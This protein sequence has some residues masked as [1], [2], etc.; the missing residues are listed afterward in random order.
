MGLENDVEFITASLSKAFAQRAGL[1]TC[2]KD[3]SSY[4]KYTSHPN[5]FSSGFLHHEVVALDA[6]LEVIQQVGDRRDRLQY[7]A[8][9]LRN[10]LTEAGFDLSISK[11]HILPLAAGREFR[12]LEIRDYLEKH[13][14]YG[15]VFFSPATP[16][17]KTI[18][19]FT[20]NTGLSQDE[21]DRVVKVCEKLQVDVLQASMLSA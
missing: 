19:R 3:F 21:M 17:N 14:V 4:F 9:Y 13:D 18:M 20:I 11:S 7:N 5:I 12:L 6:S 16:R 8:E 1:I 10:G 2:S 15:A